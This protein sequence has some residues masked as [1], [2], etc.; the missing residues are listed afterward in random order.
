MN[1]TELCAPELLYQIKLAE[2]TAFLIIFLYYIIIGLRVL[3]A[4]LLRIKSHSKK[5]C[6][7]GINLGMTFRVSRVA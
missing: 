6:V 2:P 4:L 7:W 3:V 1:V 5:C